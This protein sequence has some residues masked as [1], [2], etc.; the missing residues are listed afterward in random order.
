M[1]E[2]KPPLRQLLKE[3]AEDALLDAAERALIELGY[4]KATMQDIASRAGCA[5]GTLYIHFKNKDEFFRAILNRRLQEIHTWIE[6]GLA[7]TPDP[8]ARVRL[9]VDCHI[10]WAHANTAFV[11]MMCSVMPMR[12][13][14][15]ESRISEIAPECHGRFETELVETILAAQRQGQLRKDIAAPVIANVMQGLLLTLID[16]F[17]AKPDKFTL[18]EQLTLSWQFIATGLAAGE[19][20][21]SRG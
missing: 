9:F 3:T 12:Y 8:L 16:Q 15:F 5:V 2:T 21:K 17:S 20:G 14:D 1:A 4:E 13:Y 6:Q 7:E 10:R 19:T 11:N 18:K